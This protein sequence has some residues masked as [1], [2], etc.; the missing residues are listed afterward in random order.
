LERYVPVERVVTERLERGVR[1][2]AAT[3]GKMHGLVARAKLDPTIQKIAN[4]IRLPVTGDY[5]G[6]SRSTAEAVYSWVKKSGAFQRDPFQCEQVVDPLLSMRSVIE[7]KRAGAYHGPAVFQGDCDQF[8]LLVA[9]LGGVLGFSYRFSTA[10]VDPQRPDEFSHVW[11]ELLVDNEWL[12]LDASTPSAYPG[13]RPPVSSDKFKD[14]PEPNIEEALGMSGLNGHGLGNNGMPKRDVPFSD[15]AVNEDLVPDEPARSPGDYLKVNESLYRAPARRAY[16]RDAL[17]LTQADVPRYQNYGAGRVPRAVELS[18]PYP[19]DW[20]W[21]RQVEVV[22]PGV[23]GV[24]RHRRRRG[25]MGA[26]MGQTSEEWAAYYASQ[27]KT[28]TA[29]T[30]E[31]KKAT[32]ASLTS[33]IFG[34]IGDVASLFGIKSQAD[35]ERERRRAAEVVAA[36]T[37]TVAGRYPTP[38]PSPGSPYTLPLVLGGGALAVGTILYFATRSSSPKRRR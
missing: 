10:R 21:A 13:W 3:I 16:E 11:A 9:A 24:G 4:W 34:A 31:T 33:M 7:A 36:A 1:G 37:N 29:P 8:A 2:T 30:E 19:Y 32:E 23:V 38:T 26:G 17:M 28:P 14:W 5:F 35:I 12:P 20:P 6:S 15:P 22:Y 18:T 25:G 27:P